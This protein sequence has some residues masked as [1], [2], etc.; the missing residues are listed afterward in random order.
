MSYK[1]G[2]LVFT[3]KEKIKKH[4]QAVIASHTLGDTITDLVAVDLLRFHPDWLMKSTAMTRL[5]LGKIYVDHARVY[6]TNILIE[7]QDYP[8]GM[9][10]S[11]KYCIDCLKINATTQQFL[12]K[13]HK[14]KVK[15]AA[16]GAILE[17][18]EPYRVKGLHVDH[19]YPRTFARLLYLFMRISCLKFQDIKLN[20]VDGINGGVSWSDKILIIKWQSFHQRLAKLRTIT[21][22]ENQRQLIYPIDWSKMQ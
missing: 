10:I 13:D 1:L 15:Q 6:S 11:W 9:D 3:S 4:M 12:L 21:P 19:C 2:G 20:E 8:G 14:D 18:I 17:Q 5:F 16:R 22:E 7:R